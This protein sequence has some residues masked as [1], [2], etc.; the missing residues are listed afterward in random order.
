MKNFLYIGIVLAFFMASCSSSFVEQ[1]EIVV[2]KDSSA[3]NEFETLISH[4][5][6]T[7]D[8]INSDKVPALV[9]QTDVHKNLDKYLVIDIRKHADY[10][11]GHIDGAYNVKGENI[12]SFMK[13]SIS[14][15]S[16]EKVVI[17]C[18]SG[19]TASYFTSLLRL[20]GYGNVYA[21]KWG[22]SSW[23]PALAEN[24]W[25][26][27][28][29][30][31]YESQVETSGNS[32]GSKNGYPT[33]STGKLTGFEIAMARSKQIIEEGTKPMKVKADE[34]FANPEKYYIVN[35]WPMSKYA[36]AHIPGAVQ[37]EPK[38][39][40]SRETYLE[41]LPKDKTIV[42]YCYTGQ[43]SAFVTAYLRFLGYDAK[44]LLYGANGFMHNIMKTN[45]DVGHPFK[46]GFVADLPLTVGENRFSNVP[47]AE[48]N[49]ANTNPTPVVVPK[50]HD[51][52]GDDEGGC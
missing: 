16:Y 3:V 25:K 9:I 41:T 35:Y 4:I 6:R 17:A 5:E 45:P 36:I 52:G 2:K 24:K 34:V 20:A 15:G 11:N 31:A 30:S 32:K 50:K 44:S 27:K 14:A 18:Y 23:T 51:D 37:Y 42:V 28:V 33:I 43:H 7:G 40:L 29:G 21:M 38:K 26:A 46:D 1:D 8:L 49:E 22:M 10:V 19:Q 13:D 39:S 12:Y 47:K 48:T